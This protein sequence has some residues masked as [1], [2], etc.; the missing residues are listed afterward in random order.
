MKKTIWD[1]I[2]RS[3][4]QPSLADVL[5]AD[6]TIH[7]LVRFKEAEEWDGA[8][9]RI[10][11]I[12]DYSAKTATLRAWEDTPEDMMFYLLDCLQQ[13]TKFEKSRATRD[14]LKEINKWIEEQLAR[15]IE[16][17]MLWKEEGKWIFEG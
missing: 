16:E 2:E 11:M 12:L 6:M 1:G 3:V 7:S 5:K 8:I 14:T 17:K 10:T 4:N 13:R 9:P 15:M